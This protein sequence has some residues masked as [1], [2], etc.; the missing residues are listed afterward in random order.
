MQQK[1]NCII[2]LET[3]F[4]LHEREFEMLRKFIS[5]LDSTKLELY[6]EFYVTE[7][8]EISILHHP[9]SSSLPVNDWMYD[10][11]NEGYIVTDLKNLKKLLSL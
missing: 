4:L 11:I 8:N 3:Y 2:L 5:H 1:E 7:K 10:K 9:F 6:D